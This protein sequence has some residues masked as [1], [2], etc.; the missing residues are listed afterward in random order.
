MHRP[1][2]HPAVAVD[3]VVVKVSCEERV[4][5]VDADPA[6]V[7]Q[8]QPAGKARHV[9]DNDDGEVD[10]NPDRIGGNRRDCEAHHDAVG[11]RHVLESECAHEARAVVALVH[12]RLMRVPPRSHDA[13]EEEQA[14]A[15]R[16]AAL[17]RRV[18]VRE[19]HR[20]VAAVHVGHDQDRHD[21]IHHQVG[22]DPDPEEAAKPPP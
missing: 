21:R 8:V 5:V 10:A 3:D 16:R 6:P 22:P 7:D 19:P 9:H 18:Q 13:V 15:D 14:C 1:Q 17:D 2:I 11:P 12:A 20:P 4:C